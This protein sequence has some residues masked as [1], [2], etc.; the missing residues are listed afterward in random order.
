MPQAGALQV[1]TVSELNRQAKQLLESAFTTVWV[2]GEIS[3]FKHHT[4][5]HMY[6]SLKDN[7]AE[8]PLVLF[9]GNARGLTF[10]PANGLKVMAR[11]R[12]TLY[13]ARGA[14]QLVV[15]NLYPAGRGDLWQ[16]YEELK[17]SL[18]AEGLFSMERKKPLPKFP[19][20]IGVITSASG[21]AVQDIISITGRRGS[22]VE[23]LI[24]P[25]QVQGAA[26]A[27][28]IVVALDDLTRYGG[29]DI[30]LIARG[31]GSLEDLWSFNEEVVARAVA[32]C[33]IPT[34]SAI[35]HESDTTIC[36]L[37]ADMRAATPSAA[38][39]L[40]VPE[41]ES[42]LQYIDELSLNLDRNMDRKIQ[43]CREQ[44]GQIMERYA[45]R[46]PLD[47]LAIA[48]QKVAQLANRMVDA[49]ALIMERK[50][51]A[52]ELRSAQLHM[53]D[54]DQVMGRGYAIITDA[55]TGRV[56]TRKAGLGLKQSLNLE[57]QDGKVGV[58]VTH[59]EES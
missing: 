32:D 46:Q 4:S 30:I 47:Q 12:I 1:L 57:L 33:P 45:F 27:R 29:I 36:D 9:A 55:D 23:L 13:E 49:T 11:G 8:L 3:N 2:E 22:H 50:H 35:G 7:R 40:A 48:S 10:R 41:R 17:A 58:S 26:S 18:Q 52:V 15:E 25:T 19:G 44:L 56:I 31:G 24:R 20:K 14:Y 6:F 37:V 39:E 5:G 38:A 28:D 42:Y 34:I 53:L 43:R 51:Q 16:A 21:A 54:P 59:L